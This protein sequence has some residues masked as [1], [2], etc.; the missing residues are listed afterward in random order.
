MRISTRRLG[1]RTARYSRA[2][3]ATVG[4][5][6]LAGCS[7]VQ[8]VKTLVSGPTSPYLSGYIGEVAADEPRAALVARDVLARGGN[9]A[10]AAA[11]LGMSLSVTLPSRASLGAGGAC[12]AFDAGSRGAPDAILFTPVAGPG[13]PGA[14]RPASAPMLTR[15]LFL[16]QTRH[17]SVGFDELTRPAIRLARDGITVSRALAQDLA[18]VQA[19][20]LADP[21]ARAIFSSD[22]TRVPVAG[23]RLVQPQLAETLAH[24]ALIGAGD[25]YTGALANSFVAGADVAGGGLDGPT[26]RNAL[27]TSRRPL[28]L[29]SGPA[30][31]AFLP[32]PAD[33]GLAA[34]AA[35]NSAQDR[36]NNLIQVSQATAAAWRAAHPATDSAAQSTEAGQAALAAPAGTAGTLASLPASTSFVVVDRSGN[37]VSCALS[38]NN[39]FGTGRVAGDT[40]IVMAASPARVPAPLLAAAIAWNRSGHEFRAAVAGSGQNQAAAAVAGSLRDA[41]AG[42]TPLIRPITQTGR[43]NVVSCPQGLPGDSSSCRGATDPRGT[44]LAIGSD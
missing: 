6:L 33:G 25:L 36:D 26:L 38:M 2:L 40:G 4:L 22:G 18:Q 37:A 27:P 3:P 30:S 20:L 24:I 32:P 23:D 34:A 12:L 44:G 1:R 7:T 39:L 35:F 29:N 9:A 19:P 15:G 16:M 5:C 28:V 17:G 13:G 21:N 41:L 14:D 31:I 42:I 10:D 8:Q 43:V 11:A